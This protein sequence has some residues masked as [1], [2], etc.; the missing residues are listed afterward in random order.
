MVGGALTVVSVSVKTADPPAP[1]AVHVHKDVLPTQD[2]S[3]ALPLDPLTP[4][5]VVAKVKPPFAD[6][7]PNFQKKI[8]CSATCG[9]NYKSG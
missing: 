2:A 5:E 1:V 3:V 6:V 7:H 8:Q 4:I 9:G